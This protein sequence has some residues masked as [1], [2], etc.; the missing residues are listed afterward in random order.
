M[1][2]FLE[3]KI[4][5]SPGSSLPLSKITVFLFL[6]DYCHIKNVLWLILLHTN[7]T[8]SSGQCYITWF[9]PST[10]QKQLLNMGFYAQ[11]TSAIL[12]RIPPVSQL[13]AILILHYYRI[14]LVILIHP[15]T[16]WWFYLCTFHGLSIVYFGLI[17]IYRH[18]F[19]SSKHARNQEKTVLQL[20]DLPPHL[21]WRHHYSKVLERCYKAVTCIPGARATSFR[22]SSPRDQ[23]EKKNL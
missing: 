8:K 11:S 13:A 7:N 19:Q 14:H 23:M 22:H 4:S 10:L 9:L 18:G 1:D 5:F 21:K 20:D 12:H 3:G 16:Y 17:Y 15:C 6:D 2:G